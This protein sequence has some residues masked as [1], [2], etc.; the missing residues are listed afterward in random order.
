MASPTSPAQAAATS[1]VSAATA[2][3]LGGQESQTALFRACNE[4]VLAILGAQDKDEKIVQVADRLESLFFKMGLLYRMQI[5]PR[6]V[7]WDTLN[8]HGEGGSPQAVFTLMERIATTGWSW[9]KCLH[10]TCIEAVPGDE[11][12]YEFNE[13]LCRDTGLAPVEKHSL[14]FG[15]LSAGHTNMGLRALAARMP[16]TLP[17]LSDGQRFC[18]D[19]LRKHDELF[20]EA[21]EKGLRWKVLKHEVRHLYPD[22]LTIIQALRSSAGG[23]PNPH[24]LIK[25][26]ISKP[27]PHKQAGPKFDGKQGHGPLKQIRA[28]VCP[29]LVES[30]T[31]SR[32]PTMSPGTSS[33]RRTRWPGCCSCGSWPPRTCTAA[34]IRTGSSSGAWC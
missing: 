5:A 12:L 13:R 7:G 34:G 25:N 6:Q 33:A 10:A 30:R 22:A 1:R 28:S 14:M 23:V 2:T 19:T 9:E 21:V 32:L 15:S 8:R 26:L 16:S 31:K 3:G 24:C 20:A 18:V 17:F 27:G 4:E 29:L 11:T